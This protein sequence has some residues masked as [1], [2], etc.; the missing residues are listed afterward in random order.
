MQDKNEVYC[1]KLFV[2]EQLEVLWP[3]V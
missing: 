1:S 3:P 2:H